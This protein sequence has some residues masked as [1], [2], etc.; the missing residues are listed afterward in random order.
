MVSR[1]R[2]LASIIAIALVAGG[3][4]R[5]LFF[6]GRARRANSSTV[7]AITAKIQEVE[8]SRDS[9]SLVSRPNNFR[10]LSQYSNRERKKLPARRAV[11]DHF[12]AALAA[13]A[14]VSGG[15]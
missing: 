3:A 14:D 9:A 11:A 1:R 5:E 2:D 13:A 4:A 7:P 8:P 10:P 15:R 12:T 6:E